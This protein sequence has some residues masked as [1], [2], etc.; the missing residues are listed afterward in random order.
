MSFLIW[1]KKFK[2]SF[3][4]NVSYFLTFKVHLYYV[5]LYSKL[6]F[7]TYFSMLMHDK[8]IFFELHH[9]GFHKLKLQNFNAKGCTHQ[10]SSIWNKKVVQFHCLGFNID[11]NSLM[12]T[13]PSGVIFFHSHMLSN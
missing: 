12:N 10:F 4:K 7:L 11:L 5:F 2:Q 8:L 9:Q 13:S 6:F 1:G 3:S